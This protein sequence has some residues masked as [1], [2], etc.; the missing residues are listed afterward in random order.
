M[1][2]SDNIK[3]RLATLR[4]SV[5]GKT[6]SRATAENIIDRIDGILRDDN[7]T[8]TTEN[9]QN[10]FGNAVADA[11]KVAYE[12][13]RIIRSIIQ[14]AI[15]TWR[16][17]LLPIIRH[18]FAPIASWIIKKYAKLYNWLAY[19]K[20]KK[21]GKE[22]IHYPRSLATIIGSF[23]VGY[24][25]LTSA[26]PFLSH[27]LYEAILYPTTLRTETM[28]MMGSEADGTRAGV[29]YAKGCRDL[30][31]CDDTHSIRYEI[32]HSNWI[33]LKTFFTKG[34]LF[35]PEFLDG[36]IPNVVAK[37][38]L[39]T[40]GIRFRP[41]GLYPQISSVK[42]CVPLSDDEIQNLTGFSL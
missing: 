9:P 1:S 38:E 39:E 3:D 5:N 6:D 30:S 22:R 19:T 26:I 2:D 11:G 13:S 10:N 23:I 12:G 14:T 35:L 36:A 33:Y 15:W 42:R 18:I 28:M 20:D 24:W 37:C 34:E 25:L 31:H 4:N 27:L 8:S 29:F 17:L 7:K 21:T 32:R 41:L 16:R 40:W